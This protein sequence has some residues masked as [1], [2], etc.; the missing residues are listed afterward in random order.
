[1]PPGPTGPPGLLPQAADGAG[2]ADN[3]RGIQCADV[4]AELQRVGGRRAEQAPG[5]EVGFDAPPLLGRVPAAVCP[6][7]VNEGGGR[8]AQVTMRV[9][10]H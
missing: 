5:K 4:H 2:K 3:H 9:L 6:D 1:M 8:G 10:E 7:A